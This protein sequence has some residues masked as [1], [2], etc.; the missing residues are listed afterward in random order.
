MTIKKTICLVGTVILLI[1]IGGLFG[2]S[3]K[4]VASE[5]GVRAE[6]PPTREVEAKKEVAGSKSQKEYFKE[7]EKAFKRAKEAPASDFVYGLAD[8]GDGVIIKDYKIGNTPKDPVEL[9]MY[10]NRDSEIEDSVEPVEIVIPSE[11][12]GLPVVELGD[13]VFRNSPV[14][15]VVIPESVKRFGSGLFREARHLQYVK[16]PTTITSLLGQFFASCDSLEYFIIPDHITHIGGSAF[17][18]SGLRA[19]E[20]P[21]TV[22]TFEDWDSLF[23]HCKNLEY[24]KLPNEIKTL[25]YTFRDCTALKQVIL[26]ESLETLENN[27]FVGCRSLEQINLPNTLTFIE[28]GTFSGSGLRSIS[29]P[30][31][32]TN[33]QDLTLASCGQLEAITLPDN[34]THINNKLL[35]RGNKNLKRINLPA[36]L[37]SIENGAF[38][39]L[40]SLEELIIPENLTTI[41]WGEE[42]DAF[43]GTALPLAT[44]AKLKQLGYPGKFN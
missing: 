32:V 44:Q 3:K 41:Y 1:A 23:F 33:F 9:L 34:V 15:T 28:P 5:R 6:T 25:C 19:I 12:E 27:V 42:N 4:E 14:K 31:S 11:I 24:V 17:S 38:Y 18:F 16:L 29:I 21:D 26:P 40:S 43:Y 39:E 13:E 20:I 36:S 37:Q 10:L 7:A 30:E 35:G 22:T 8:A 2:C